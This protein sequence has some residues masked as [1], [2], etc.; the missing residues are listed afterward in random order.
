MRDSSAVLPT[1]PF[2]AERL[3]APAQALIAYFGRV[4]LA[5]PGIERIPLEA[6]T[7]RILA[8]DARA[9][10]PHPTHRRSTMDGFAVSSNGVTARRR[11]AGTILMGTAPDR[12]LGSEEAMRIPTGGAVPEGADAVIPLESVDD[13]GDAIV[14]RAAIHA[15]D[16][17]T[18]PGEDIVAGETVLRAGRRLGGPELGVL[19]TLGIAHVPVYRKP[20][21]GIIST[22]DELVDPTEPLRIG[23][24]RDSNRY[25]IGASLEAL[26]VAPVQLP[27]ASDVASELRRALA[28]ALERCDGVVLTGGSSVGERDLTP[29][30][31]AQL[32]PP[33]ALVHGLRVKPG[34]PTLLAAVGAKPVIGLPGNPASAL[35]ILEAIVRPIV[36]AC[37]GLRAWHPTEIEAVAAAP[38]AGREGWTWYVPVRLRREAG[39][40]L[41]EPAPIRSSHTSLLARAGGYATIGEAPARIA[42]GESI[43]IALFACGGAPVEAA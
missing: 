21:F 3:L 42:A 38:F 40:T 2:V 20:A 12:T 33:G 1:A 5:P 41:A 10:E 14:L 13:D 23:T 37:T 6:C 36:A 22:G 29:R 43:T 9:R 19:A 30:V 4:A 35:M 8:E 39:R 26:G 31:V 17:M 7:G 27:R 11:I 15:G 32:G 28:D 16:C 24:V 34:K 18:Q 25:A